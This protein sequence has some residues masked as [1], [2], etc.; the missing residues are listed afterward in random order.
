[1]I[2]ARVV[3]KKYP[4]L[5]FINSFNC[6]YAFEHL[7]RSRARPWDDRELDVMEGMKLISFIM[8]SI[9]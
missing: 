2:N 6:I 5:E 8:T 4:I 3:P 7:S 9:C 1:M